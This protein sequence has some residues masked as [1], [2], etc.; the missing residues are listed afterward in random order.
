[1]NIYKSVIE[2]YVNKINNGTIKSVDDL[3]KE[4][5][6]VNEVVYAARKKGLIRTFRSGYNCLDDTYFIEEDKIV[7]LS[8]SYQSTQRKV[9]RYDN[10]DDFYNYLEGNIANTIFYQ[11][12]P[13]KELLK[14]YNIDR[15]GLRKKVYSSKAIDL[16]PREYLENCDNYKSIENKK[17]SICETLEKIYACNN[18][19][20]FKD[21]IDKL[22]LT[23]FV[24][25]Q[26]IE[27]YIWNYINKY[28]NTGKDIVLSFIS[29]NVGRRYKNLKM[30][31]GAIYGYDTIINSF[32]YDDQGRL[33]KS[34]V[35]S[36]NKEM[37]SNM[38]LMKNRCYEIKT[39]KYFDRYTHFFCIEKQYS[40]QGAIEFT[41]YQ[42]FDS[43]DEFISYLKSDVSD[44]DFR[45]YRQPISPSDYI[46]FND[47]TIF[48]VDDI[49]SLIKTITSGY[50]KY[51]KKFIV[52]IIWKDSLENIIFSSTYE[53]IYFFEYIAFLDYDLS[54]SDLLYCDGLENL[55]NIKGINFD[56]AIIRSDIKK[57]LNLEYESNTF[58]VEVSEPDT[59]I[60]NNESTLLECIDDKTYQLTLKELD[61]GRLYAN[62][63][64]YISDIHLLHKNIVRNSETESD[65]RYAINTIV[66][67]MLD[68]FTDNDDTK[69]LG[70]NI[71]LIGGD[72]ASDRSVF[73]IFIEEL[74]KERTRRAI[75]H[76]I[77][78]V[79]GNHE[80]WF[81]PQYSIEEI[82]EQYR[83]LLNSHNMY[84]LHNEL[85]FIDANGI[86]YISGGDI[87]PENKELILNKTKSAE[88]ILFGGTGFVGCNKNFN[89][90]KGIYRGTINRE[91]EIAE[92]DAFSG[93]YNNICEIFEKIKRNIIIF[94]HMPIYDWS[95]DAVFK[96]N[97][98]YVSGHTHRNYR[99]DDGVT[100]VYADNQIGYHNDT[101]HLKYLL[102]DRKYNCLDCYDDDIHEITREE[103]INFYRGM[104]LSLTS[105]ESEYENLYMLKKA[106]YYCFIIKNKDNKLLILNGGQKKILTESNMVEYYYENMMSVIESIEARLWKYTY[107][108]KMISDEI[109]KIAGY[110]KIHGAI[111]YID[112][113]NDASQE[114]LPHCHIFLDPQKLT[115]EPYY[116]TDKVNKYFYDS[117][118]NL[119]KNECPQLYLNY[120]KYI[121]SKE[122]PNNNNALVLR[123]EEEAV[124]S[125]PPTFRSDTE[126]YE[127]S[128]DL[129]KMQ[130]LENNVL[131]Y[132]KEVEVETD[133]IYMQLTDNMRI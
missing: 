3:P 19:K 68:S 123:D 122:M 114:W 33:S 35:K 97:Y 41:C 104:N 40:F 1:M 49:S 61:N 124:L 70:K 64:Y 10:F 22:S 37:R 50:D 111:I 65:Y 94:T 38:E 100:R 24:P 82:V 32:R 132:W 129:Y 4:M 27:F 131:T 36:F 12:N 63:I 29:K 26:E 83:I 20:T 21:A 96:D 128:N 74:D 57:K 7:I 109:K 93:L 16:L 102:M 69:V 46:N 73:K 80:L 9:L 76:S 53:F 42:Y 56:N 92:S 95:K 59:E 90:N 17:V 130:K 112:G 88:L 25:D 6:D 126:M 118:P 84:L 98:V 47:N 51:S 55:H 106:G 58:N 54:F 79:L 86:Q 14:K 101:V 34:M 11:W 77:I 99:D 115:I 110:G 107:I 121:A 23:S 30:A 91:M 28:G 43:Y 85:M 81:M 105:F 45:Y 31:L 133:N 48:P 120:K 89:A 5:R 108:Q 113:S 127:R 13:S 39:L 60:T 71:L 72:V 75:F 2:E 103:Y 78:F 117:I 44:C 52:N 87:I 119:L 67:E 116:A 15:R 8:T 125:I 66:C 62:R 18:T